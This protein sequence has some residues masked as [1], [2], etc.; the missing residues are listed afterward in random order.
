MTKRKF[1][2]L[3][4]ATSFVLSFSA[5]Q[6]E[7]APA[8]D[9]VDQTLQNLG[10][11]LEKAAQADGAVPVVEEVAPEAILPVEPAQGSTE[12]AP[13]APVEAAPQG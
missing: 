1:M 5:L 8:N 7:E 6:A 11:E 2:T 12:Q 9:Q 3:A 10:A 4:L 13:A